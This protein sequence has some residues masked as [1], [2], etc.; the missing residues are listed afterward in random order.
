MMERGLPLE[1]GK[2]KE[3]DPPQ[4]PPGRN[5]ALPLISAQ[6]DPCQTSNLQTGENECVLFEATRSLLIAA[7]GNE[8]SGQ[9]TVH[10][11]VC[12]HT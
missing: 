10:P 4:E 11:D 1:A 2:S 3:A 12:P 9:H 6:G 7:A 5:V 8:D